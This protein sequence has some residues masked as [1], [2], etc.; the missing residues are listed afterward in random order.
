MGS[1]WSQTKSLCSFLALYL[2][3]IRS[4]NL[5]TL[6]NTFEVSLER[7]DLNAHFYCYQGEYISA[8][9]ERGSSN[10]HFWFL[11]VGSGERSVCDLGEEFSFADCKSSLSRSNS[12]NLILIESDWTLGFDDIKSFL[13]GKRPKLF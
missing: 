6:I 7:Y 5:C 8:L 4:R 12:R 1:F 11:L 2:I 9:S 10:C 13:F 3:L